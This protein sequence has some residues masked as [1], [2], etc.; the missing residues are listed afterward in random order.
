MNSTKHKSMKLAIPALVALY[1]CTPGAVRAGDASLQDAAK[2]FAMKALSAYQTAGAQS[3]PAEFVR[4]KW[5]LEP[6]GMN[7]HVSVTKNDQTVVAD[8]GLPELVGMSFMDV[9]DVDGQSIGK[10]IVQRLDG[11]PAGATVQARFPNPKTN[12]VSRVAGY[13]VHADEQNILCAWAAES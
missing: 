11:A 3:A 12:T 7:L 5:W 6:D 8:S 13:C 4:A 9:S 1:A 10:V 2:A